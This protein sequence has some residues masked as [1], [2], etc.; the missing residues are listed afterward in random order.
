MLRTLAVLLRRW[1]SSVLSLQLSRTSPFHTL[2]FC[3]ADLT[4]SDTATLKP[5]CVR[6]VHSPFCNMEATTISKSDRSHAPFT[7]CRSIAQLCT[8]LFLLSG[9]P[10]ADGVHHMS[11]KAP[12]KLERR[13]EDVTPLLVTNRCPDKIWPAIGTQSGQGPKENGFKLEPG[14]T[15]NQTVSEDWQGRVWGRTN[16]SF[17]AD[18]SGP[19]EGRGKAC[20]SGDCNGILNCRV[21]VRANGHNLHSAALIDLH[22]GRRTRFS[23]RIH[24]RCRRWAYVL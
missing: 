18:G 1:P 5:D 19:A 6:S 22:I 7:N 8:I 16:C 2:F 12:R 20:Y 14:E 24:P 3:P 23:C 15:K 10:I 21:G 9:F 11:S 17:R 4:I 13:K